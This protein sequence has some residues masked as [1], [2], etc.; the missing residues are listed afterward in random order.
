MN[1]SIETT[2]VLLSLQSLI[3]H[4]LFL[5]LL[6]TL[7]ICIQEQIHSMQTQMIINH[8]KLQKEPLKLS[9]CWSSEANFLYSSFPK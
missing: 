4:C 3:Y 5:N 7:G 2:Q 8:F 1:G 9:L 6:L